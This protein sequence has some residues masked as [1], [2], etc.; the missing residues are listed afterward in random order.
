MFTVR[1]VIWIARVAGGVAA[2]LGWLFLLA[3]SSIAIWIAHVAVVGPALLGWLLLLATNNVFI[4]THM[5][6]G[7]AFA[8]SLLVLGLLQLLTGRMRLLG[9]TSIAYSC[10]EPGQL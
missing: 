1:L 8:F 9:A 3:T 5:V 4:L 2:L 6:V 10:E 7:V